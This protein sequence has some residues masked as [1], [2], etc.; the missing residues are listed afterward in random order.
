[1]EC[2]ISME[3]EF[4]LKIIDFSLCNNLD[5][6]YEIVTETA[7]V[8][9]S[10]HQEEPVVND[11]HYVLEEVTTG[12]THLDSFFLQQVT[13][14]Y[15]HDDEGNVWRNFKEEFIDLLDNLKPFSIADWVALKWHEKI[16]HA[17][18][19][20]TLHENNFQ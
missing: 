7:A 14:C 3:D 19:V 12:G 4:S 1:M 9:T 16:V 8:T 6:T 15:E 10:N 17:V 20:N 11:Q 2:Q 13:S 5:K 18:E